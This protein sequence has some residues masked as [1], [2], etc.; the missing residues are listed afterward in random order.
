MATEADPVALKRH[1]STIKAACTRIKTYVDKIKSVTPSV[2][3]QLEER[4]SK[5]EQHWAE[6]HAVQSQLEIIDEPECSDR[7]IFEEAFFDLSARIREILSPPR[8]APRDTA[9]PSPTTSSSPSLRDSAVHVRLPKLSLPTFSGKYDDWFPFFDAFNSIIHSNGS[10]SNVHKLQYLRS[11][12]TG[13]ASDVISA[14]EISDLNY[15]IAWAMLKERYDNKRV[16]VHAHVKAI[17]ELPSM[18]KENASELR[19]I[20]DGASKHVHAL[21]ALNRPTAHWDDLLVY[22]LSSKLDALTLRE[23]QTSLTGSDIPVFKQLVDFIA[24]RCQVIEATCKSNL[25]PAKGVNSRALANGK[26]QVAAAATVK[27]KCSFCKG[28]HSIYHCKDFLELSV[29]R[30]KAEIRKLKMCGNC[31]RSTSHSAG[32]CTSGPCRVCKAKHNTLLHAA[33]SAE[34]TSAAQQS[35]ENSNS[36][37][38]PA[39]LATHISRPFD[40]KYAILSTAV[41]H[42]YDNRNSLIPCRV[43]LD[44]GSQANFVSKN[45]LSILGIKPRSLN[46]SISGINGA[47]TKSTQTVRLKMQSRINTFSFDTDCIVT[48]QVTDKLPS[49]SIKRSE[50]NIPRGLPLADPQFHVSADVDALIGADLFWDLICIGQ[51]K[52]SQS[53]PTLQKTRLGWILAGRHCD[54][55]GSIQKIRSCH[56]TVSNTQLHEQL[57]KFWRL[58]DVNG[59]SNSYTFQEANCEKHFLENVAQTPEGRYIVKLPTNEQ[60][61]FRLGDSKDIARKRLQALE[62]RFKREAALKPLY[63]E[64]LDEY[65]SL[66]HMTLISPQAD[67]GLSVYLPHHGIFKASE[68]APKLRVVFDASCKTSTGISLNDALIVGPVVQQDLM[69]ILMRFRTFRYAFTADII[70]MYRQILV[71]TS[72]TPLQRILWRSDPEADIQTY[73]LRTVTYGTASASYLATRCL[74]HLAEQ[75]EDKYPLGSKH[76]KQ[77]FYVDDLLT[78]AD[79]LDQAKTIREEIVQLL[80][81]GSFE[82]SKWSSNSPEL[83]ADGAHQRQKLITDG[84]G[85]TSRILGM[86]WDQ[87]KDTFQ[88]SYDARERY[89]VV[90]KRTILSGV[91]RLFD[92]LGLL[93][94]IIVTA[95]LILQELWRAG[96]HW[97]ESVPQDIHTRWS[98]FE[99]QLTELTRLQV[100]RCIKFATNPQQVEIHGFADASQ[101]AYGACLYIRTKLGSNQY[102]TELLCSRSRVAPLKAISLPR[103]ELAAALLLARLLEKTRA[104]LDL[105]R[106]KIFLWSDSTITLNWITSTSRRWEVFVANRTGEIQRLTDLNCWRHIA[107]SDNP[108]DILSRGLDPAELVD[109]NLWWHG[110]TFLQFNEDYWPSG[111]F[112]RLGAE[113]PNRQET[114]AVVIVSPSIVNNL[115]KRYSNI[116]KIC[117]IL[118]YC[119]RL[120]KRHRPTPLT[121]F[122]PHTETSYALEVACRAVQRDAF[123]NE[124]SQLSKNK[125]LS[126]SS[127][128]LSLSPFMDENRL[129]RVGG[130][131]KNSDLLFETRHPILLPRDHE[132]TK[133]IIK[134][135]HERNL[136][137][138]THATMA[139]VRQQFWP[140]SLRSTTRKII[141][142]CIA[143]FRAKPSMSEAVM[144]SLPNSRVAISRPFSHCGV[145]YAG[146]IILREGKRRNARNHKAYIA[147]FVCFATK[148]VHIEL[149]SD[150]TSESFIAALRRFISRR[151]RPSCIYSD[152][153]TV[154]VG[155]N[156]QI[157]ELYEF[158]NDPRTLS[159][160]Q[161]FLGERQTTWAFIPPNAPHFGGL[162][163]AAVKS[164]KHHM[165]RIIGA[166]HLTF[167]EMAT[168]LCEIEGILNSRPLTQLSSDPNDP[169]YLSPGHFLIGAPINSLPAHDLKDINE[170]RLTRW[171]RV[172]QIR[173]H[174]WQRWSTEYLHSLQE[175]TKWKVN[176]GTQLKPD[177][178]VLIK[179][180]GL[181]PLQWLRG[182]VQE[183]HVGSDGVT[184]AATVRTAKGTLTRPLSKLAILPLDD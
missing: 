164:A 78:G 27:F 141:Q 41:V 70:K 88:I 101:Q 85:A 143:C 57:D 87:A 37:A 33:S 168:V 77:D 20:A 166:A 72:Q 132:L 103:L 117:R 136:H 104:S 140:L 83:I 17:M 139:A 134:Q 95:K 180:Q 121:E 159:D 177:Q 49:H 175:R 43:L 155:A 135:E 74:K 21:R 90:S 154:F 50:F 68:Q 29:P 169:A 51:I 114:A 61:I 183:L 1:R 32:E 35:P 82:L 65:A 112:T 99:Q 129:L 156:K 106:M 53:H 46:I 12:L 56:A 31:L 111:E 153:G 137:A 120:S 67:E 47:I 171:Q 84:D 55:P 5:L 94:P 174:F 11:S 59:Q 36:A 125:P 160:V 182:R 150:L 9:T 66:G 147:I 127:K 167:E 16:I 110:P 60:A 19:Q 28:D 13:E 131:L 165:H 93:G 119:L 118:A 130:R 176:K 86:K 26:R 115:L 172:E 102:R 146:P 89:H 128:L 162:W 42:V 71:D 10:L 38:S 149:V 179:Q 97:D 133:R 161:H 30:R 62:K 151:G 44:C 144:A 91:A 145:D 3:A 79:T 22:I 23:W 39:A 158:V 54:P 122:I 80:R 63:K 126:T 113:A 52:A 181:A 8:A 14:L 34:P 48:D 173:Q 105:A 73:E 15:E 58:E 7:V 6:Y 138:G 100:P 170:N 107:S 96:S 24:H 116:N 98:R 152:N 163:E 4:R 123:P 75:H 64:F 40:G 148:G 184:R 108:A 92:P 81:L 178:L 18:T 76:V 142:N 25:T 157:K 109:A 45:F 124:Y 2:L 69:S